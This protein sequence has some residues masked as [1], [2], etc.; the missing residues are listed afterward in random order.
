MKNEI[1][2]FLKLIDGKKI[3]EAE[4]MVPT[5]YKA[6]DKAVQKGVIKKNNGARKKSRLIKKITS[7]KE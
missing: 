5:L 3:E 1:K 7:S 6:I 2:K 4:K